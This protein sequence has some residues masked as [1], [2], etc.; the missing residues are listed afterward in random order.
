ME[1][2]IAKSEFS[3]GYGSSKANTHGVHGA[4]LGDAVLAEYKTVMGMDPEKKFDV[5]DEVY[6]FYK[7]SY[8][9]RGQQMQDQWNEMFGRVT[10]LA[11][12][13]EYYS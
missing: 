1:M 13:Y 6:G 7:N 11:F 12:F 8:A 3:W 9:A 10:P 5:S 4:P 2:Q